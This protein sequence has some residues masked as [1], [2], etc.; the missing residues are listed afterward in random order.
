[1]AR[2]GTSLA[3]VPRRN[4]VFR[5]EH[6]DRTRLTRLALLWFMAVGAADDVDHRMT[7]LEALTNGSA[8]RSAVGLAVLGNHGNAPETEQEMM[9]CATGGLEV[10]TGNAEEDLG[11]PGHGQPMCGRLEGSARSRVWRGWRGRRGSL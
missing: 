10:G 1:M 8:K 5:D 2:R 7:L 3:L 9:D 11:S 6:L 4:L